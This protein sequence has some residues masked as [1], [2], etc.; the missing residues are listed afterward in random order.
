MISLGNEDTGKM[1]QLGQ[2]SAKI[3][4][5][6]ESRRKQ[7]FVLTNALLKPDKVLVSNYYLIC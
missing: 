7:S 1:S 6:M 3:I 4:L 2:E 5:E